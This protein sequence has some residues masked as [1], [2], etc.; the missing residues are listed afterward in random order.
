MGGRLLVQ[1]TRRGLVPGH[2]EGRCGRRAFEIVAA[3]PRGNCCGGRRIPRSARPPPARQ[4][5]SFFLK[6]LKRAPPTAAA[7]AAR[8]PRAWRV[9]LLAGSRD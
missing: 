4:K 2:P 3:S 8:I 9:N 5:L 6:R 7:S 1:R